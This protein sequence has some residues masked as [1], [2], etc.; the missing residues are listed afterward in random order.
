[1][2]QQRLLNFWT[3]LFASHRAIPLKWNR[4]QKYLEL[5]VKFEVISHFVDT[6]IIIRTVR[7]RFVSNSELSDLQFSLPLSDVK[8]QVVLVLYFV[9]SREKR[10]RKLFNSIISATHAEI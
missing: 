3:I 5:A 10:I 8:C 9:K 4:K 7:Q 2:K 6:S 1:M